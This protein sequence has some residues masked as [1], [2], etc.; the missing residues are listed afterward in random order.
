M[1]R[2]DLL[3]LLDLIGAPHPTFHPYTDP[4]TLQ[5]DEYAREL[6]RLEDVLLGENSEK[7]FSEECTTVNNNVDD[8]TPFLEQGL[9]RALH[10]ISDP[11]PQVWHTLEDN[12]EHLDYETIDRINRIIRIFVAEYL[13]IDLPSHL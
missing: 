11:F 7:F 6:S 4:L 13:N 8:H 1:Q 12:M 5:C 10:V 3:V 9:R 2:I